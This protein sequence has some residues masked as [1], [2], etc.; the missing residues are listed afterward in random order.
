MP[1]LTP[2]EISRNDWRRD[3]ALRRGIASKIAQ[4]LD[5]FGEDK[6]ASM[7]VNAKCADHPAVRMLGSAQSSRM[8][9]GGRTI[10]T[11]SGDWLDEDDR[12]ALH[13]A[14]KDSDEDVKA[15]RLFDAAVILRELRSR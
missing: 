15:G 8:R 4:I 14:L 6:L 13:Q 10:A 1:A 7:R 12:A 11:R 5:P 3:E 2:R 9:N